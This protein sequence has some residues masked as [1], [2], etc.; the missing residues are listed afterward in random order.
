LKNTSIGPQ[1]D[2][3]GSDIETW[4]LRYASRLRRVTRR[5]VGN[6]HDAEDAT[7]DAFLAAFRAY[8]RYRADTDPYPWL[9]R[10]AT[11]K[12]LTIA[13]GHR[14]S[15]G[16]DGAHL[17]HPAPSAEDEALAR[18]EARRVQ[19]L[20]AT[21]LPV[22]MHLIGG[23]R[24]RDVSERLGIPAATA[25]TRI[26]RGKRRLRSLLEASF[27]YEATPSNDQRSKTA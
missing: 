27:A 2:E 12:A 18:D 7:Q 10:I 14:S 23:L 16:G 8:D 17:L 3:A 19:R 6:E 26:R 25:A 9:F 1:L 4:Y 21:E 15:P 13:A 24:F 22:A 20:V 5:I 11:R